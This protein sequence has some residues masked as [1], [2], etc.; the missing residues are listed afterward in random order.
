M[1]I[2]S[3]YYLMSTMMSTMISWALAA[4]AFVGSWFT[5]KKMGLPGWKGIIPYYNMYVMFDKVWEKKKFWTYVI[6]SAVIVVL[7]I[8][9]SVFLTFCILAG[10][11]AN[12]YDAPGRGGT[13]IIFF[14]M[15][16]LAVLSFIA[17]LVMLVL[18][19]V[20]LFKL[21]NRLAKCFGKSTGFAFGLLF[22]NPIFMMILGFGRSQYNAPLTPPNV[23]YYQ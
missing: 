23:N 22:L 19:M 20:L 7:V 5:F 10:A 2:N 21:Y 17:M 18:L 12:R 13:W 4:C 3:F 15:L 9:F 11:T 14:V 1:Y 6:F 8:M 16:A